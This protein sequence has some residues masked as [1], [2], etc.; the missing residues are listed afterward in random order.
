MKQFKNWLVVS[1][2][3]ILGTVVLWGC[4][5]AS[6]TAT[7]VAGSKSANMTSLGTFASGAAST[8]IGQATLVPAKDG[9]MT[10]TVT[11][12]GLTANTKHV[13]HIH[14]G[15][16]ANPGPV[17]LPLEELS[18]DASGNGTISSTVEAAKIPAA[19]YVQYHQRGKGDP[20]GAGAGI[21]CGDIK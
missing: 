8:A 2:L 19:A 9:K 11:I 20:A 4:A 10:V 21:V 16:C 12:S 5:P 18:S 6:S 3:G 13:G 17:A 15:A 14:T 1:G 7:P